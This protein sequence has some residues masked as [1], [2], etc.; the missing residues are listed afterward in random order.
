MSRSIGVTQRPSSDYLRTVPGR[1]SCS[2]SLRV[3][4]RVGRRTVRRT[5]N[6]AFVNIFIDHP[7]PGFDD[8]SPLS[9]RSRGQGWY[10]AG[11]L[12]I[13]MAFLAVVF[14]ALTGTRP[15]TAGSGPCTAEFRG[16][17][18]VLNWGRHPMC[19]GNHEITIMPAGGVPMDSGVIATSLFSIDP[20][21]CGDTMFNLSDATFSQGRL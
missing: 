17:P 19:R 13:R 16:Q 5:T 14:L 18:A 20:L 1:D 6:Q 15:F 9:K 21:L 7:Y 3:L 12:G 11:S 8:R 2:L 10:S 4:V